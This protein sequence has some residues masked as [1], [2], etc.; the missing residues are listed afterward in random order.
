MGGHVDQWCQSRPLFI[1]GLKQRQPVWPLFQEDAEKFFGSLFV[2]QPKRNID[3]PMRSPGDLRSLKHAVAEALHG[4]ADLKRGQHNIAHG[5]NHVIDFVCPAGRINQ[6]PFEIVVRGREVAD[7]PDPDV[8]T[9]CRAVI[10]SAL[11]LERTGL[12]LS[13]HCHCHIMSGGVC[14]IGPE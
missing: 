9:V 5:C 12:H 14:T 11:L 13:I 7:L 1:F 2:A 4:R 3:R 6:L 10:G 8:I